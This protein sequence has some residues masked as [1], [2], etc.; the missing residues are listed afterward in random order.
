M[1][2]SQYCL[3]RC[4]FLA[5]QALWFQRRQTELPHQAAVAAVAV[6]KAP[7]SLQFSTPC[8][9]QFPTGGE[10]SVTLLP[11]AGRKSFRVYTFFQ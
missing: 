4:P 7:A 11:Q 10:K 8:F 9:C 5:G 6:E 3:C 1:R 2:S